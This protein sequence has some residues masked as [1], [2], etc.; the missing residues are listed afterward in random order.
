MI[1]TEKTMG[2]PT[3]TQADRTRSL[4]SPRTGSGPN[5]S[6]SRCITFSVITTDESTSTPIEI[7]IPAIDIAL[8]GMSTRPDRRRAAMMRN[9]ERAASGSVP[10]ITSEARR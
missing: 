5:R 4:T 10:A 9:D 3:A 6:L 1:A 8:A 7:A 2:R